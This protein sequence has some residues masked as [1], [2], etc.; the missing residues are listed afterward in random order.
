MSRAGDLLENPATG[1]RAVVRV[2]TE[3]TGG[4]LA[5]AAIHVSPDAH[6]ASPQP[7]G[8][9]H[10]RDRPGPARGVPEGGGRR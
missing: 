7:D 4:G 3:E 1:E 10:A 9:H 2:G 8:R 5:V 6:R